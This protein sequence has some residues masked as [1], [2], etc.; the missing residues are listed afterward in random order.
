MLQL[1]CFL[2]LV[3]SCATQL[4]NS[5]PVTLS[6]VIL[7][8]ID[9]T[10]PDLNNVRNDIE[11]DVRTILQNTAVPALLPDPSC[12]C[13]G[14]GGW[15]RIAFLNMSD[16]NEQ[17]PSNWTLTSTPSFR[18]CAKSPNENQCDSAFF[19][20]NGRSYL[21]LCGR[22]T[23]FQQGSTDAFESAVIRDVQLEGAYID[24][25]SL[26][27]G[28]AGSR[29]HI[30]T[31]AASAIDKPDPSVPIA[32]LCECIDPNW[33]FEVPNFVGSNYFCESGNPGPGL[34]FSEVHFEN[35]LWDGEGCAVN[36]TCCQFNTPP[37]FCR[38]LP[39]STSDDIELRLCLDQPLG[40]ESLLVNFVEIYAK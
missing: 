26:T 19:S 6:P 18:G 23:A 39:E 21:H 9:E 34:T 7:N 40:D 2:V 16:P 3:S 30:W 10:C 37:W 27:H 33:P 4:Q 1:T 24:G 8:R 25:V 29:Q 11:E 36:T 31:F 35:P 38:T 32:I 22:I 28:T 20:A 12:A 5:L 15:N 13:G 17:C 14:T